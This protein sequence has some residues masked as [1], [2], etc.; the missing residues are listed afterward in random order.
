[1]KFTELSIEDINSGLYGNSGYADYFSFEDISKELGLENILNDSCEDSTYFSAEAFNELNVARIINEFNNNY[2]ETINYNIKLAHKI[3]NTYGIE[4][5]NFYNLSLEDIDFKEIFKRIKIATISIIRRLIMA[6]SNFIKSVTNYI[7][8]LAFK[9]QEK[10]YSENRATIENSANWNN[11]RI[12]CIPVTRF[13]PLDFLNDVEDISNTCSVHVDNVVDAASTVVNTPDPNNPPTNN[14]SPNNSN[15]PPQNNS[16]NGGGSNTSN[17][18][19]NNG[20]NFTASGTQIISNNYID[21][22]LDSTDNDMFKSGYEAFDSVASRWDT[23][24]ENDSALA[25]L[26]AAVV[27]FMKAFDTLSENLF[28]NKN[29]RYRNAHRDSLN[30]L[31]LSW[32]NQY[33]ELTRKL[34]MR[35]TDNLSLTINKCEVLAKYLWNLGINIKSFFYDNTMITNRSMTNKFGDP[36]SN[37]CTVNTFLEAWN[38]SFEDL[39]G[40]D[41]GKASKLAVKNAR[42]QLKSMSKVVKTFMKDMRKDTKSLSRRNLIAASHNII[43]MYFSMMTSWLLTAQSEYIRQRSYAYEFAK[44]IVGNN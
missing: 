42:N 17:V 18:I 3:K 14:T 26:N 32:F 38:N 44:K 28:N 30:R 13:T 25:R 27:T 6:V 31:V 2:I 4:D 16:G 7:G 29:E 39:L 41:T 36:T 10:Y 5:V 40:T 12:A 9:K 21:N 11:I 19:T 8:S 23:A 1:M 35:I 24:M 20:S 22:L 43:K 37:L 34:N 33:N 15:I